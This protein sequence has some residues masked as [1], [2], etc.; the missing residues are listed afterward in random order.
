MSTP[1]SR[2]FTMPWVDVQ[3]VAVSRPN[4]WAS[5]TIAVSSST[6]KDGRSGSDVRVLPPVAVIL[7]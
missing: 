5:S 4:L 7:M 2:E 1:V 6:S 3:W